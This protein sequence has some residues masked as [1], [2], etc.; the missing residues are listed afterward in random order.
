MIHQF[1]KLWCRLLYGFL[2]IEH[3]FE[4]IPQKIRK[5]S[6]L[7]GIYQLLHIT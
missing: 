7:F 1:H 4:T 5:G 6:R 3:L 2:T